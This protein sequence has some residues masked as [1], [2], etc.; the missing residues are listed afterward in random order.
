MFAPTVGKTG[1]KGGGNSG[2]CDGD[3]SVTI[4]VQPLPTDG[5]ADVTP[6]RVHAEVELHF[7][8][9]ALS[10]NIRRCIRNSVTR[11]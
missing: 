1:G 6:R 8:A 3:A 9:A 2:D 7:Q 10:P 5:S 4:G 11:R